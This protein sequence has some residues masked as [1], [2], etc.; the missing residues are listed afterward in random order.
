MTSRQ[1]TAV[2]TL[3]ELL[4]AS[5]ATPEFREA[6]RRFQRVK[7]PDDR[8]RFGPGNPPVKVLRALCGL[9]ENQPTLAIDR[10]HIVASSGC[11]DYRGV[12]EVNDGEKRFNFVW[13]CAWKANQMG[14]RDYFGNP[15]QPRAAQT[16]G[17]RCFEKF[18]EI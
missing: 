17:Y 18:E 7:S 12:I 6:A 4:E 9:L 15:D 16:F 5:A 10:I 1:E 2:P 8:I 14:W 11:S 13:D 3:E